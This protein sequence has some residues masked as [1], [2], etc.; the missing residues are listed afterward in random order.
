MA[1]IL[2]VDDS[3]IIRRNLSSI[4]INMGHEIVGEATDGRQAYNEYS[5]SRPD[6]VTMDVTM[7]HVDGI[8]AVQKIVERFPKAKIIM[9]STINQKHH[10]YSALKNGA[11]HYI[12]K[13][14]TSEKVS[15]AVDLVLGMDK[16]I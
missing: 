6:I 2:I 7:P 14:F 3:A 13:P 4:F 8:E 5:A 1:R 9:I 10:V 11:K 15:E 16:N 12:L